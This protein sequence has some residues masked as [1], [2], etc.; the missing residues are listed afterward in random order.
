MA[1]LSTISFSLATEGGGKNQKMHRMM[2]RGWVTFG[3]KSSWHSMQGG[4]VKFGNDDKNKNEEPKRSKPVIP[5]PDV[6]MVPILIPISVAATILSFFA[7]AL[8]K[9][10][11][12]QEKQKG[13]SK[14]NHLDPD[15]LCSNRYFGKEIQRL[16]DNLCEDFNLPNFRSKYD[17]NK[18][19]RRISST[20]QGEN[21]GNRIQNS[22]LLISANGTVGSVLVNPSLFILLC[23]ATENYRIIL[24]DLQCMKKYIF[25]YFHKNFD[26]FQERILLLQF[27]VYL[28]AKIQIDVYS[29][30]VSC[31]FFDDDTLMNEL[32]QSFSNFFYTV[33]WKPFQKIIYQH[34]TFTKASFTPELVEQ[35]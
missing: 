12:Y 21:T 20:S 29:I 2:E 10:Y 31:W 14:R 34:M 15:N 33:R 5:I 16:Q 18:R 23:D 17:E 22:G 25:L 30:P 1:L 13:N 32:I 6:S 4:W 35:P 27:P 9:A 7:V 28:F 24:I 26:S 8:R 19:T 3:N 11:H